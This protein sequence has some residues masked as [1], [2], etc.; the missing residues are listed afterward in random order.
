M[1]WSAVNAVGCRPDVFN[2]CRMWFFGFRGC[3]KK[4]RVG[5][6]SNGRTEANHFDRNLRV[7]KRFVAIMR[8]LVSPRPAHPAIGA[9][10]STR[11]G[12]D[13]SLYG[14]AALLALLVTM[15]LSMYKLR[16]MTRYRWRKH[17]R[18]K[19]SHSTLAFAHCSIMLIIQNRK[20]T[21]RRER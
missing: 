4:R 6:V 11:D 10:A 5:C 14:G 12:G 9:E 2:G 19:I 18:R 13:L 8:P 16:D 3:R 20:V 7:P 15:P 17:E 1:V 21:A